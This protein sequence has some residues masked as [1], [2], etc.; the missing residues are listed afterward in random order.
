MSAK[1]ARKPLAEISGNATK[2][3]KCT[4]GST[5]TASPE[6]FSPLRHYKPEHLAEA[7]VPDGTALEP[8]A[9]FSLYWDDGTLQWIVDATNTYARLKREQIPREFSQFRRWKPLNITELRRFLSTTI[10]MGLV[11]LPARC[12]YWSRSFSS[13]QYGALPKGSLSRIRYQQIKRYLHISP[14]PA[15][16][17]NESQSKSNWWHKLEPLSSHLRRRSQELYLPSTHVAM[18]E[19][20]VKFKGRSGHTIRMPGKPIP[21]GYKVLAICDAGYTFD[22]MY[23]SCI[24]SIAGLEKVAELTPTGLAILQ[25]CSS[26]DSTR[27]YIVY[28]D[29]AFT[30]VPLLRQLRSKLIGGCGTTRINSAELP[31]ALKSDVKQAWNTIDEFVVKPPATADTHCSDSTVLCIRWEDNNIVRFLTTVHPWNE[32]TLSERRKPRTTSTNAANIRRVFG[33]SERKTLF[34]PTVVDDYNRHMNGVDLADQRRSTYTTHQRTRRNWPCLFFFLLDITLVNAHLIIEL[35][36]SQ[37]SD[38]IT[39]P[40]SAVRFRRI[41]VNQLLATQM[42]SGKIRRT[43]VKK[44]RQIR[45]SKYRQEEW[46]RSQAQTAAA[47]SSGEVHRLERMD[48]RRECIVCRFDFREGDT[49]GRRRPKLTQFEC[50]VC[51]PAAALCG[52]KGG[53]CWTRWHAIDITRQD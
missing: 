36:R 50:P 12:N 33:T 43:H 28:T 18:D 27:R 6:T 42:S 30:T 3:Q 10:F 5:S 47:S 37:Q 38:T 45:F 32:V 9:F 16:N 34:I 14:L 19:M 31:I 48:K 39:R 29:N 7:R 15:S 4:T 23:T 22:W 1:R 53:E 44:T 52:P 17:S 46:E 41:L 40:Y 24:C 49:G 26:L 35:A 11:K 21:V 51:N 2:K 13:T 20:M 8:L 25:L